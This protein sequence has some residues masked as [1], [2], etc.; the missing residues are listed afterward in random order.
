MSVLVLVCDSFVCVLVCFS[1][2]LPPKTHTCTQVGLYLDEQAKAHQEATGQPWDISWEV[3]PRNAG[4]IHVYFPPP[5]DGP[6]DG[7]A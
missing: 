2:L 1:P 5:S 3:D 4:M 6:A 7:V